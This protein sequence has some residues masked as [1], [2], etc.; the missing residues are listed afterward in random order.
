MSVPTYTE[1][2]RRVS[3]LEG[4]LHL[5][6]GLRDAAVDALVEAD[7]KVRQERN[8]RAQVDYALRESLRAHEQGA[9][10]LR[11]M[12]ER[13]VLQVAPQAP[14]R[15]EGVHYADTWPASPRRAS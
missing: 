11:D 3:E 9:A 8:M 15:A 14:E 13:D 10:I 6:R 1:L 4:Q 2:R 5:V 7:E 12:V